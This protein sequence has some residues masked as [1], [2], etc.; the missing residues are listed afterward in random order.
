MLC[1]A[2]LCS[3]TQNKQPKNDIATLFKRFCSRAVVLRAGTLV[4]KMP[5]C[6]QLGWSATH[7]NYDAMPWMGSLFS[8]ILSPLFECKFH[9]NDPNWKQNVKFGLFPPSENSDIVP[10]L[11]LG[12][13]P[14]Q[15]KV[16]SGSLAV[17]QREAAHYFLLFMQKQRSH[18]HK[19][20]VEWLLHSNRRCIRV[21]WNRPHG[22]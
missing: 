21:R 1:S 9:L 3:V 12:H 2:V 14:A 13:F 4:I 8:N 20:A 16:V 5:P 10:V 15:R 19:Q 17:C 6:E 7:I 11:H 22:N 18:K